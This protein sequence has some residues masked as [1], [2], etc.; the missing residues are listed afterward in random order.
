MPNRQQRRKLTQQRM[1]YIGPARDCLSTQ[2]MC[3]CGTWRYPNG[4]RITLH[5]ANC[6]QS[7]I[8]GRAELFS[9]S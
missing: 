3:D 6:P 2:A 9:S 7:V 5:H 1:T 8:V 4:D